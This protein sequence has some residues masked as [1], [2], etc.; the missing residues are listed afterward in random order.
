M[1]QTLNQG[2]TMK[3]SMNS[4]CVLDERINFRQGSKYD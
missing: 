1:L 2:V 3:K 4:S